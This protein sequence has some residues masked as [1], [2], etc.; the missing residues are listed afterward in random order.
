MLTDEQIREVDATA[1]DAKLAIPSFAKRGLSMSFNRTYCRRIVEAA[2][3]GTSKPQIRAAIADVNL[4]CKDSTRDTII[5]EVVSLGLLESRDGLLH[6]SSNGKRFLNEA[7]PDALVEPLL[8]KVFP[9]AHLLREL[10]SRAMKRHDVYQALRDLYP[11]WTKDQA[12]S[13][14]INFAKDLGLVT[15]S[16]EGLTLTPYGQF[17]EK[18]LPKT[19]PLPAAKKADADN[20]A[21]EVTPDEPPAWPTLAD[22][23]DLFKND[24][25][26]NSLVFAKDHDPIPSLHAAWHCLPD[27]RFAILSGL[28]GTGKTQVALTYARLYCEH[29]EL[30]PD[31]HVALVPV[32][33]DWRDPSGLLGYLN[34][35]REKQS[36]HIEPALKLLLDASEN[37]ALPYFLILDEMN[38]ARV[39]HYFAPLLSAMETGGRIFLHSGKERID[40]V[41]P[42]LKWP[43]N[44]FI[45]GTVNMDET[46]HPFSDKV[47][48][49]AFPL[50]FWDVDLA[51]FFENETDAVAAIVKPILTSLYEILRPV[52]RHF[53][54]RTAKEILAFTRAG[55][56]TS[57][58]MLLDQAIFSKVLPRV[59]GEN[60]DGL[61]EALTKAET[62]CRNEKLLRSANKLADMAKLLK[63]TGLTKF[64]A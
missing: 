35:L 20:D 49:R 51:A 6:P 48:D 12:Q 42:S 38:L 60:S 40:G 34:T 18:R 64:W 19:L 46:T 59:R 28:S 13:Q 22:M 4:N 11:S 9:F 50:E 2:Q 47:L 16:S 7:K 43:T 41:P 14:S 63:H 37:E 3:G 58:A 29:L 1:D 32:S 10:A 24:A 5:S 23:R 39:E 30:D 25:I 8:V 53:G 31:E 57:Q 54:Y 33:P 52:R 27:K 56:D 62:L 17:W 61:Q 36:F 44:L 45:A 15:Q 21:Q 55:D 26:G